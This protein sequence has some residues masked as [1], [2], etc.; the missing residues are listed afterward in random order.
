VIV[1]VTMRL[2]PSATYPEPRDAIS[3]DWQRLL[4][5]LPA[6]PVFVPNALADPPGYLRAVGARGLLLT[7]GDS[8]GRLPGESNGGHEWSERDRTETA[9]LDAA[10]ED[11]L[12]V[13]GVCRGLQL[14]NVHL[15]GGLARDLLPYGPH[16]AVEHEVELADGA[17]VTTNSFHDNAVPLD[18]LARELE[19]FALAARDVVEGLRHP[20][21]PVTA[22]QWH[23]ER[24]NPASALDAQILSAWIEQCA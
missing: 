2:A 12:P 7:G 10:L 9:L 23:P 20:R 24:P 18:R 11:G 14:V 6:T 15:G 4:D 19:P 1:A 8:L 22:V 3:H 13:L 21:L 5:G 16:V 17:C